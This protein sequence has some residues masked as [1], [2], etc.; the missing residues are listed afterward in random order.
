MEMMVLE[1]RHK[2]SI[3]VNG[4]KRTVGVIDGNKFITQRNKE[5]W[6]KKYNGIGIAKDALDKLINDFG[7]REIKVIYNRTDGTQEVWTTTPKEWKNKGVLD[8]LGGFEEQVFLSK[9]K[10]NLR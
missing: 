1:Q 9:N 5:H 4:E 10:F 8:R 6:V 2:L 7:I 3:K